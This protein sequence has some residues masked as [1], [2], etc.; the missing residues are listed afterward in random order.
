[1]NAS[2]LRDEILHHYRDRTETSQVTPTECRLRVPFQD[3]MGDPLDLSVYTEEG[4]TVLDD[5]GAI[6]G[7]LFSLDQ[8]EDTDPGL[9][10]LVA[11]ADAYGMEVDWEK[12]LVRLEVTGDRK[13]CNAIQDITKLVI[14]MQT[15]APQLRIIRPK[16]WE[17]N[18]TR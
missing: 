15:A 12:G 8:G 17:Q 10:L 3:G 2:E 18:N 4:R 13:L 5:G 7:L 11:I 9:R 14:T 16:D 1:M 6:A